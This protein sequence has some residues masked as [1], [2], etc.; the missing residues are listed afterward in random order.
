MK[1]KDSSLLE[2]VS[3]TDMISISLSYSTRGGPWKQGGE[4]K[5]RLAETRQTPVGDGGTKQ[6]R[7]VAAGPGLRGGGHASQ[8]KPF[9]RKGYVTEMFF[10]HLKSSRF[11]SRLGMGEGAR[12]HTTRRGCGSLAPA[13]RRKPMGV[14][15][16]QP[17]GWTFVIT[18]PMS[19]VASGIGRERGGA[20]EE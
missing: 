17:R 15:R 10:I 13:G 3:G 9:E 14:R 5:C 20:T 11:L 2:R 12:A 6:R 16:S 4:S 19:T 8:A 7:V 18:R 1:Q